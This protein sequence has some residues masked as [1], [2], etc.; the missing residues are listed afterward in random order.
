M[1]LNRLKSNFFSKL[2]PYVL[3]RGKSTRR[4]ILLLLD[5]LSIVIALFISLILT[6]EGFRFSEFIFNIKLLILQLIISIPL[7]LFSGQYITLTKFLEVESIFEIFTRNTIL[8][9]STYLLSIVLGISYESRAIWILNLLVLSFIHFYYRYILR[10]LIIRNTTSK[11][12]NNLKRVAIYGAGILGANLCSTL[13]KGRTHKIYTFFDE[14]PDLWK[15]KIHGISIR[16]L[17]SLAKSHEQ[18]DEMLITDSNLTLTR[19]KE[20]FQECQ[21][22]N[23]SISTTPTT[24]EIIYGSKKVEE[25]R[26]IRIEDLLSRSSVR[27]TDNSDWIKGKSILI[28]GAG[29]SI[30]S[31]LCRQIIKLK[32]SKLVLFERSE[33]NLYLIEKELFK[34]NTEN[35]ELNVVLGCATNKKLLKK[36]I[37]E[38]NI[39]IIFHASAYKH[40][41]LVESNPLQG[42]FNN[43]ISTK[44][45]VE[46]SKELNIEKFCLISTDK[47]VR[48]TNIM[49]ASKRMAELIVQAYAKKENKNNL[50]SSQLNQNYPLFFMVR[51]GNVLGSS[52]SVVPLF[53]KQ[54]DE[55]GPI[56]IT[57]PKVVR[58][59]MSIPEAA[60]L[61]LQSGEYAT[62]GDVFIL[63]MG[64]PVLIKDLAEQMI[65]LSGLKVKNEENPDGDISIIYTGLRKGE[66]L[67]E[68]L[69]IDPISETTGNKLIFKATEKSIH[70]DE[71]QPILEN[72]EDALRNLDKKKTLELLSKAVPEWTNNN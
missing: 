70:L 69:L 55:G 9:I 64:E 42:I 38:K 24:E 63:D 15:R 65:S 44:V 17:K 23:I 14:N 13:M 3:S 54:I 58:Y 72:L 18:I 62:G 59:F 46:L 26:P 16:S 37:I 66:K 10:E 71:L 61:V 12:N 25:L 41:P 19:R 36:T 33:I 11:N 35:F 48:P 39:N 28:T 8:I 49:G 52:G 45:L 34:N 67:Y 7:Y 60:S 5:I 50:K 32:P 30:G 6:N 47:A 40:V 27:F 21:K 56:T 4:N 57:D 51:F 2:I 29:G 31:E 22:F 20:I 68:E 53:K 43:V 1:L